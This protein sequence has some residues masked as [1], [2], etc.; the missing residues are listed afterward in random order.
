MDKLPETSVEVVRDSKG[1]YWLYLF[2]GK[3]G[4]KVAIN[5]NGVS[6]SFS[7]MQAGVILDVAEEF[8]TYNLA[9]KKKMGIS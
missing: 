5:L 1:D 7:P 4:N 8:E 2:S 3:T 6:K 9:R